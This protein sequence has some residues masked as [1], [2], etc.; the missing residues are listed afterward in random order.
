MRVI[1]S[2]RVWTCCYNWSSICCIGRIMASIF[3]L[4]MLFSSE[5]ESYFMVFLQC[6]F[7]RN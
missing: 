4:V 7:Y 3:S 6:V 2:V 1:F 5:E